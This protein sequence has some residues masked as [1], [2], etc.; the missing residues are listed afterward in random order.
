[1]TQQVTKKTWVAPTLDVLEVEKTLSGP[2]Y[3]PVEVVTQ[4]T[5][6]PYGGPNPQS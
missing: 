6:E 3:V 5:G 2:N 4:A 1:M